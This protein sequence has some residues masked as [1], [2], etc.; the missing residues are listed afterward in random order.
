M[1][2]LDE[3]D[4][5]DL[6]MD[7]IRGYRNSHKAFKPGPPFERLDDN[8]YLRVIGAA[9]VSKEDKKLYPTAAGM[10]MF[11]NKYNIVRYFPDY[12][13]NYRKNPGYIRLG[14]EQMRS[15]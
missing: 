2:V 12:F 9:G 5:E 10:L 3:A 8:E 11:G 14:K 15:A 6:N 1:K 13:L 7:S 4:I